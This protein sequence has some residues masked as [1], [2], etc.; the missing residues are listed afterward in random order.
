MADVNVRL[1]LAESPVNTPDCGVIAPT[2]TLLM[3]P[4]APDASVIRAVPLGAND[5]PVELLKVK[6]PT[7][8]KLVNVAYA[9]TV[10][11]IATLSNVPVVVGAAVND[12]V[13]DK[14]LTL[15]RLKLIEL[16][17]AVV[18]VIELSVAMFSLSKIN[19]AANVDCPPTATELILLITILPLSFSCI[20]PV[21]KLVPDQFKF[22]PVSPPRLDDSPPTG[23]ATAGY[24][25]SEYV[26]LN[27]TLMPLRG[28]IPSAP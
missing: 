17:L 7:D 21:G 25:L 4:T 2:V 11:P 23:T 10:L 13:T 1:P 6:L 28:V 24:S 14:L 5:S 15:F 12:V 9:D 19:E 22:V 8:D 26:A 27:V 3:D 18:A 20:L 16:L